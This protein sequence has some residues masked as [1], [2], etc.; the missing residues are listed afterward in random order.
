MSTR[1]PST[2]A[3][4]ADRDRIVARLDEAFVDGQLSDEDRDLRVSQALSARTL[5]DLDALVGDL[6][7]DEPPATTP[8]RPRRRG[9]VIAGAVLAGAALLG[10]IGIISAASTGGPSEKTSV[11]KPVEVQSK[12]ERDEIGQAEEPRPDS[13]ARPFTRKYFDDFVDA[14]RNRFGGTKIYDATFH[15]DG[16][17]SFSRELSRDRDDLLQDW[18]WYP[19]TGFE[20]SSSTA[21]PNA[22][23]FE[24]FDLSTINT[25]RLAYHVVQSRKY[26]GVDDPGKRTTV[27]VPEPYPEAYMKD[28]ETTI[29]VTVTND[30]GDRGTRSVSPDGRMLESAPFAVDDE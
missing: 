2:R 5:G 1:E 3:R 23:G 29:T 9:A 25:E 17:V 19:A 18:E 15:D 8:A 24:P 21:A 11:S 4:D 22:V 16:S 7:S 10:G 20:K 26:L 27:T 30:Y 12:A 13:T 28:P 14:Y 6:Q